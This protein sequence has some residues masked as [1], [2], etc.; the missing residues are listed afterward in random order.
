MSCLRF[1]GKRV[2]LARGATDMR[3]SFNSLS[4]ILARDRERR[5]KCRRRKRA[6]DPGRS[7]D[8]RDTAEDRRFIPDIA[9]SLGVAST[10]VSREVQRNCVKETPSFLYVKTCN[11]CLRRDACRKVDVCGNGCIMPCRSCRKW[12]CNS[13]CPDFLPDQCPKLSKPPFVCN[14]C[15]GLYGSGCD[16]EYRFYD[17]RLAHDMAQNRKSDARSG[18]DVTEERLEEIRSIVRGP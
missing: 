14:G 9:R 2:F 18:I 7:H 15:S 13:E 1:E 12:R 4:A 8:H 5:D 17:G 11:I 6:T 16:Y 3:K 10:T